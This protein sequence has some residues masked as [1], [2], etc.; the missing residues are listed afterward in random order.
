MRRLLPALALIAFGVSGCATASSDN[1]PV[2]R[3]IAS[4]RTSSVPD[5]SPPQKSGLVRTGEDSPSLTPSLA[6]VATPEVNEVTDSDKQLTRPTP[7][8]THVP[9]ARRT[10][11]SEA[12]NGRAEHPRPH[13]TRPR[14]A[15]PHRTRPGKERSTPRHHRPHPRPHHRPR[16]HGR[17]QGHPAPMPQQP[18]QQRPQPRPQPQLPVRPRPEPQH[19]VRPQPQPQPQPR[20]R[21]L[22]LPAET[23]ELR[24][25]CAMSGVLKDKSVAA[26]CKTA[27]GR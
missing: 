8:V 11:T 18:V 3:P 21:P 26:L 1:A 16:P 23:A 19:E 12:E 17:P 27:Y 2:R 24:K 15:H 5:A 6:P 22:P 10:A 7:A 9:S 13:R 25:M 4:P 14:Q 20:P